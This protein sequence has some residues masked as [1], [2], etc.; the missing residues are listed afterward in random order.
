MEILSA[1]FNLIGNALDRLGE[2][3]SSIASSIWSFFSQPLTDIWN[4]IKSIPGD[5]I[6]MFRELLT[7]LFVP[8]ED[9]FANKF[10]GI[11]SILDTKFGN[12]GGE[13]EGL[14]NI[15]STNIK[16][17]EGTYMGVQCKIC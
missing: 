6:N 17:I 4:A 12:I 13:L 8:T 14:K 3:I 2:G 15:T 11:K 7:Y 9:Y 16:D 10:N 5:I 1:P